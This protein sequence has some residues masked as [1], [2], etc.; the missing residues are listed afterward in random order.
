MTERRA[1]EER[2]QR[3]REDLQERVAELRTLIEA[4]PIGIAIALDPGARQ[5]T[6]NPALSEM[7][8]VQPGVNPS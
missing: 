4:L 5:I 1:T 8:G 2:A 3:E 6:A 7:F